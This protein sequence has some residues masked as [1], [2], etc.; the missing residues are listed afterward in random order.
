MKYNGVMNELYR[1]NAGDF[2]RS[3]APKVIGEGMS[4]GS[5]DM[6]NIAH[7]VPSIH[8]NFRIRTKF[9][10]HH[11]GFTEAAGKPEA[12]DEAV[13]TSKILA[14]TA[15]DLITDAG[16]LASAKEEF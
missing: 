13:L 8:P 15:L 7:V 2:G 12:L 5:T 14:T 9:P 11:V 6:G 3:F 4:S 10:N 1:A 16:H